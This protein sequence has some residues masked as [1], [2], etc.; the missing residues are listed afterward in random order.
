MKNGPKK[1]TFSLFM[2]PVAGISTILNNVTVNV[3]R[4][5]QKKSKT[6]LD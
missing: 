4:V 6:E 3:T 1:N 5:K 2:G